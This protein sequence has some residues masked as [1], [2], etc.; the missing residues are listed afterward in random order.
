MVLEGT[1]LTGCNC[2]ERTVRCKLA[3][4]MVWEG[5]K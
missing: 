4:D 2:A 5:T 1:V 3:V